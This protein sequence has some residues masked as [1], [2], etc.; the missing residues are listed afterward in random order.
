MRVMT[1]F[2]NL[3]QYKQ[4]TIIHTINDITCIVVWIPSM[5]SKS[6]IIW[7]SSG[8]FKVKR[9]ENVLPIELALDGSMPV[10]FMV[11]K[12]ASIACIVLWYFRKNAIK[13]TIRRMSQRKAAYEQITE[14]DCH[15][16][17]YFKY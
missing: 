16:S 3:I 10:I 5:S 1:S 9:G 11:I 6:S 13:V 12:A 7:S 15:V 17:L 8:R 14:A 2:E 4:T